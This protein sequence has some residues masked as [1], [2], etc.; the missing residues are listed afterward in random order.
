MDTF[1]I[2][3]DFATTD[4]PTEVPVYNRA[5]DVK[6][7]VGT[8]GREIH[9]EVTLRRTNG[10]VSVVVAL[11]WFAGM[12]RDA[13]RTAFEAALRQGQRSDGAL[14]G[15]HAFLRAVRDALAEGASI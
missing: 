4:R 12:G 3:F 2:G 13:A 8:A 9:G 10:V 1:S 6:L 7:A 5:H 14:K 15:S 11:T